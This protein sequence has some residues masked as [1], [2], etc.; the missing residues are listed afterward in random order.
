MEENLFER[1]S[2]STTNDT[3]MQVRIRDIVKK[4]KEP[5]LLE[6]VHMVRILT[7]IGTLPTMEELDPVEEPQE[8]TEQV[9]SLRFGYE[10]ELYLPPDLEWYSKMTYTV[11]SIEYKKATIL[12]NL[13]LEYINVLNKDVEDLRE[14]IVS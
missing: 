10:S 1:C 12:D 13:N 6:H 3:P 9:I 7:H 14:C 5:L 2:I 8:P 11:K 4:T